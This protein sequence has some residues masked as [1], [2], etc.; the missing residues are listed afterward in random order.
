MGVVARLGSKFRVVGVLE[1]EV[2]LE[3]VG[4]VLVGGG[5]GRGSSHCVWVQYRGLITVVVLQE[6][7]VGA[8]V[9][10]ANLFT[11]IPVVPEVPCFVRSAGLSEDKSLLSSYLDLIKTKTRGSDLAWTLSPPDVPPYRR[12]T[13]RKR[14]LR[15]TDPFLRTVLVPRL[16]LPLLQTDA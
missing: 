16:P 6:W 9:P 14:P 8:A 12:Q 10:S 4:E 13:L 1:G 7:Y 5:R 3:E 15:G 11:G 2:L